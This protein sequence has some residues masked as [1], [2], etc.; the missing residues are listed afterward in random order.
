M[1]KMF[2][3]R[4]CFANEACAEKFTVFAATYQSAG[5]CKHAPLT[6]ISVV[7]HRVKGYV[8]SMPFTRVI[9]A[10]TAALLILCAGARA[11]NS[12]WSEDMKSAIRLVGG[13]TA[14]TPVQ[15]GVEMKIAPGWHTY[16]RY[17]GDSG[18]TPE[19]DFSGSENLKSAT[20][21]YPAPKL[22]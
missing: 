1:T 14:S 15:A 2:S 16:W 18:V 9:A 12:P 8:P 21:L 19:F 5:S 22:H 11:D 3:V 20:V 10:S 6:M 17:P 7:R 4:S 13:N